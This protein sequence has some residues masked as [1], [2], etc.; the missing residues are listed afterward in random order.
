MT[1]KIR[2]N[3]AGMELAW[4]FVSIAL[5]GAGA[6]LFWL[7]RANAKL[8]REKR[9]LIEEL[10][11]QKATFERL[12]E[13]I[14]ISTGPGLSKAPERAREEWSVDFQ[15]MRV[16]FGKYAE[17]F[18]R[19]GYDTRYQI[20]QNE[21]H[22]WAM[23]ALEDGAEW[24]PVPEKLAPALDMGLALYTQVRTFREFKG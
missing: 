4:M 7:A 8:T 2:I 14:T 1:A 13:R 6:S 9:R 5:V 21:D 15:N 24:Q 23:K 18:G 16:D 11:D 17:L 20:R 10:R 3:Y 22:S 12:V 19:F